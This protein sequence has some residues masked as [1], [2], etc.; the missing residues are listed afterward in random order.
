MLLYWIIY[1]WHSCWMRIFWF[2]HSFYFPWLAF[3]WEREQSLLLVRLYPCGILESQRFSQCIIIHFS[4]YLSWMPTFSQ[5]W[6]VGTFSRW[7]LCSF[8]ISPSLFEHLITLWPQIFQAHLVHHLIQL[9]IQPFL[10]GALIFVMQSKF[11]KPDLDS[12][13]AHHS[14]AFFAS[15]SS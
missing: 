3:C 13:C 7:L 8:D 12:K 1:Y 2:L 14:R 9:C 15:K 5:I 10:G 11:G 4:H 6:P